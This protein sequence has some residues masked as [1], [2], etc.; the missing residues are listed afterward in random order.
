[1]KCQKTDCNDPSKYT[2]IVEIKPE[3][4]SL[5]DVEIHLCEE[6]YLDCFEI[7]IYNEFK[8]KEQVLK[9]AQHDDTR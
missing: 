3:G 7:D 2:L 4:E 8:T 6:H 9:E 5:F 1:M